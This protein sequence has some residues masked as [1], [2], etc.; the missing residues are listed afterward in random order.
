MEA[1]K[2]NSQGYSAQPDPTKIDAGDVALKFGIY[3]RK[4]GGKGGQ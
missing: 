4:K 2:L 1:L 3:N